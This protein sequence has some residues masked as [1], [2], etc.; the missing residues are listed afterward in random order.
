MDDQG[1]MRLS[2]IRLRFH[3]EL[4]DNYGKEEVE[5]FFFILTEYFNQIKRIDLSLQPEF[6]IPNAAVP[7]YDDALVALKNSKPIQYITGD[8]YFYGLRFLVNEDV[9]I[10]RPETEELVDWI[11]NEIKAGTEKSKLLRLLDI[12]TGSGCIAI[13]LA[14]H[15]PESEI[16]AIDVSDSALDCAMQN[17]KLNAVDIEFLQCDILKESYSF[18]EAEDHYDIVVSNPPY[19][20]QSES[21]EMKSNVLKY[22]PHLALFVEDEDALQFYKHIALFAKNN[23]KDKGLL[24]FEINEYLG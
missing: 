4:D 11:L 12:G 21:K 15:M 18:L 16:V 10:P 1:P 9:L 23:L 24:F 14:K 13:S 2:E 19:V 6:Q 22:E 5:S 3:K 17:A 7:K 20:R 8:T